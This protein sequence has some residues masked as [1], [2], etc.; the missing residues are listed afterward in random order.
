[1]EVIAALDTGASEP[2]Q[3][4][5]SLVW[6]ALGCEASSTYPREDLAGDGL[7]CVPYT[8]SYKCHKSLT[9]VRVAVNMDYITKQ[10]PRGGSVTRAS[11]TERWA[12]RV[13]VLPG[14][15][16]RGREPICIL[17]SMEPSSSRCVG[18][19]EMTLTAVAVQGRIERAKAESVLL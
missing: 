6:P 12:T 13:D 18:W 19:G 17:R 3:A 9:L 10:T 15:S 14:C 5:V 4:V 11:D 7:L 16:Q 8:K 1:M 2:I